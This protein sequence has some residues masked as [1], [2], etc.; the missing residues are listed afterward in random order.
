L[1]Y[2][3]PYEFRFARENR[4]PALRY[5][6]VAKFEFPGIQSIMNAVITEEE[7]K[8][9][10]NPLGDDSDEDEIIFK[11]SP[12]I[13]YRIKQPEFDEGEVEIRIYACEKDNINICD[14]QDLKLDISGVS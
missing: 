5:V 13:P 9:Q 2:T 1:L 14:Y 10:L 7:V 12:E 6:Y 4:Y 11:Y 3:E 8:K